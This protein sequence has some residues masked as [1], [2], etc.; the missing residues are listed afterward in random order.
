MSGAE[1]WTGAGDRL[2]AALLPVLMHRLNNATQLLQAL[3]SLAALDA[4]RDWV[5]ERSAD[6]GATAADVEELGYVL[7]VAASGS[8]ADLLQERR[9]ARGLVPMVAAVR[10][11]LRR[12]R[13]GLG[14]PAAPLPDLAGDAGR[15]WEA[16]WAVASVLLAAGRDGGGEGALEWAFEPAGEGARLRT[17]VAPGAALRELAPRIAQAAPGLR[18]RLDAGE[19][20]LELPPGWL[21]FRARP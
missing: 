17:R 15:G 3:G 13:R 7:A 2:T 21:V 12:E 20:V 18:L 14:E 16:P 19:A 11:A 9:E 5:G 8:G 4:G 1:L 10:D 6:L